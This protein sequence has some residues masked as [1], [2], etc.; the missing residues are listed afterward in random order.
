LEYDPM[1]STW[2]MAWDASVERAEWEAG[3]DVNAVF[4][5]PEPS[6][7][8]MLAAG[9]GMLL[10]LAKLRSASLIH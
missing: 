8:L 2:E 5:V 3:A 6:P 7:L 10:V 9:A 4:F 1:S